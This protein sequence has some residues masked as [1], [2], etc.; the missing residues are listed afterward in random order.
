MLAIVKISKEVLQ[1]WKNGKKFYVK[2]LLQNLM[3]IWN[4]WNKYCFFLVIYLRWKINFPQMC[5]EVI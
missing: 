1:Q 3:D 2:E 5:S 4:T